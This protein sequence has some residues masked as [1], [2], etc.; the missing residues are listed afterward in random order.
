MN[1][2]VKDPGRR[3]VAGSCGPDC[4]DFM[5]EAIRIA[6]EKMRAGEG[7]P[8][9]AVVV[10]SGEII[11]RGWNRVTS[12]LDPTAHAEIDAIRKAACALGDFW[13]AGCEIFIN[14]EPCPMCLG[15]VYWAGIN[16]IYYAA[17]RVDAAGIG[18]ADDYIYRE[19]SRPPQERKLEMVQMLRDEAMP[20]FSSWEVKADKVSY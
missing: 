1:K 16:R 3:D 6:D 18:F 10:R 12:S 17:D 13:L 11:A 2:S 14:C 20:V 19:I 5:R 4:H 8:F 15:A 9:G 7:G